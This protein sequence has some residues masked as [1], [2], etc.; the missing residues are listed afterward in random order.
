VSVV[1]RL[2][3]TVEELR[4]NGRLLVAIDGPDAAG[5]TT[6]GSRLAQ[7][8]RRPALTACVDS[9]HHPREVRTRRGN[10]SPDGYFHDSFDLASLV[11][12]L[13]NPF[14][15][16]TERVRTSCFDYRSER[17]THEYAEV[18]PNAVLIFDGVFLQRPELRPLWDLAIYL[19]VPADITLARALDRDLD[20]FG[21]EDTVRRR[22]E[23]RYLPGQA[24]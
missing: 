3:A 6:L 8:L 9:W 7:R 2:A 5:K 20:R 19:R 16:G 24:L 13:L 11:A 1:E 4:P 17:V 15:M 18:S 12:E 14:R 21:D 10:E 22:Y 23:K